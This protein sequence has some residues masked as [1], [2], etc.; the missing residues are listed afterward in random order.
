MF[1]QLLP[2]NYNPKEQLERSGGGQ[3]LDGETKRE[4][5]VIVEVGNIRS[6]FVK[7]KGRYSLL[8]YHRDGEKENVNIATLFHFSTYSTGQAQ[9]CTIMSNLPAGVSTNT[10]PLKQS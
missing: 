5:Q 1:N 9:P 8:A 10:V 3:K 6:F 7:E 2:S 4:V